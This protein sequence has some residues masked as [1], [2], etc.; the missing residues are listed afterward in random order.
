MQNC[1]FSI[2]AVCLIAILSLGLSGCGGGGGSSAPPV[3]PGPTDAQKAAADEAVTAATTAATAATTA[4]AAATASVAAATLV[5]DAGK[6][7]ASA[8]ATAATNAATAATAAAGAVVAGDDDTVKTANEAATA[9]T[10]AAMAAT[11]AATALDEAQKTAQAADDAAKKT[12]AKNAAM[13]IA[14]MI[15]KDSKRPDDV[16]TTDDGN[17]LIIKGITTTN[18]PD[19]HG[20]TATNKF[21]KSDTMIPAAISGWM[22][23]T[24]TR[25][26]GNTKH[27]VVKYND[28]AANTDAV[29][30]DA[31]GETNAKS[32]FRS[33]NFAAAGISSVGSGTTLGVL[34][35]LEN[36]TGK[37]GNFSTNFDVAPDSTR[38]LRPPAGKTTY[39]Q[40]GSFTGVPG[41]FE[42]SGTCSVAA[43]KD[44][45]LTTLTG[46]WTFAPDALSDI[47]DADARAE[48]LKAVMVP[49]VIPDPDFMMFGYWEESVSGSN[50]TERMAP[51]AYGKRNYG[52]VNSVVKTATYT[53]SATGLYMQKTLNSDGTVNQDGPWAS[54][55]FTADAMLKANFGGGSVAAN[56]QFSV[57]GTVSNFMDGD[58][59]LGGGWTLKLNRPAE[60]TATNDCESCNIAQSSG[61]FSGVTNGG[62]RHSEAGDWSGTF[63][64]AGY[65]ATVSPMPVSASGIFDGHFT[66]GHVRGAFATNKQS[67]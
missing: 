59:A 16:D 40:A 61:T 50:P 30:Y 64:G 8:A 58:T 27:T 18:M 56:D 19:W 7:D 22:G 23:G 1:K 11:A 36:Q 33:D 4:A 62:T 47:T 32:Y 35:L 66:N 3:D 28:K 21:A 44:G 13:R 24:Y 34:A 54:G 65:D 52:A 37:H 15:D 43:D 20:E 2:V 39:T 48:A 9:A 55:Q 12:A 51:F 26:N 41:V 14:G 60:D 6:Q 67:N 17:Q 42:C 53:G 63:H 49:G 45:N 5:D 29:F 25:T 46:T 57:T 38:N 31:A 10:N